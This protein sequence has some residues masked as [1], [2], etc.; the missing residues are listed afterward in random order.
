VS[1]A[2][3]PA[4]ERALATLAQSQMITERAAS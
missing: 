4:Y 3:L 2:A 1:P